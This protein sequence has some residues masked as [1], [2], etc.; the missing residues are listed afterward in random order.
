M[1]AITV[2]CALSLNAC[3]VTLAPPADPEDQTPTED[4]AD[5]LDNDLDNWADCADSDCEAI[6]D[7]DGD[8]HDSLERGGNDC[9]D[10]NPAVN[11]DA[12]EVCDGVDNNCNGETD[13]DDP[14]VELTSWY[15]DNDGDGFG[16]PDVVRLQCEPPAGQ[17]SNDNTDCDDNDPSVH[18]EGTE[19]CDGQ[20]NDCDGLAD[21]DDPDVDPMS[22]ATFWLD[23]D[24]DGYGDVNSPSRGCFML[25]NH[26]DSDDDCDDSDPGIHPNVSEIC[27]G[28]D[29]NC[30]GDIDDVPDYDGDGFIA[31]G[32]L[33]DCDEND[34]DIHPGA[35]EICDGVDN[36]CDGVLP[37]DE[38]D[39]DTDGAMTCDGDCDDN[40]PTIGAAGEWFEDGDGDGHGAGVAEPVSC[41]SPGPNYVPYL[42]DDCDDADPSIHPGATDD[43]GDGVDQNCDGQDGTCTEIVIGFLPGARPLDD[44]FLEWTNFIAIADTLGSCP[45]RVTEI[46]NWFTLGDLQFADADVLWATDVGGAPFTANELG[47]IQDFTNTGGGLVTTSHWLTPTADNSA[48]APLVGIDP[49]GFTTGIAFTQPDV[50]VRDLSHPMARG[51][52][53]TFDLTSYG[54]IQDSSPTIDQMVMADGEVVM[55]SADG[56]NMVVAYDNGQW[57]GVGISSFAE[58]FTSDPSVHQVMY[59]AASWAA[60]WDLPAGP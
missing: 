60:G 21:D 48:L 30:D 27:D 11:P 35:L 38:T 56:L 57:R 18:P 10:D 2:L 20:D 15:A 50:T 4:C 33:F 5:G 34:I 28:I 36:D 40:D 26:T 45:V 22:Q 24:G 32:L 51:L 17:S 49:S 53:S 8:G 44:P 16:D 6:C 19:V 29:E 52:P 12:A 1:R 9:D 25:P 13:D 47:A 14:D 54:W 3:V 7:A 58:L 42:G 37:A 39:A 55:S 31:C 23:A 59:N 43:L 46:A 41:T